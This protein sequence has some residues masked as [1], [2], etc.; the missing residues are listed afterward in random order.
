M[1][2]K[3][4]I[5]IKDLKSVSNPNSIHGIYPYR[6]KISAIDA[7][8]IIEQL[9]KVGGT[10]LDPFCGS[11]TIVYEAA[12]SGMNVVGIDNNPLAFWLTNGK[13]ATLNSD[14]DFNHE[15]EHIILKAKNNN[16]PAPKITPEVLTKAFHP[17]TF[18][19]I[20]SCL[21]FF[22]DMNNY[23]RAAFLGSIAL[24]ARACNDYKWT[25]SSVGKDIQPKRYVN[26]F[27]KFSYKARKHGTHFQTKSK[28]NIILNDARKMSSYI[29]KGSIDFVFTSP[30]YFDALDYT[31]YYGQIVY[32]LFKLNRVEIKK[33]LIQNAKKYHDDMQTVFDE[34]LKVTS[35]KAVIIF[36][37]G[38]KKIKNSIINGGVF[39]SE[40]LKHKPN[41]VLERSYTGTSSQIFDKLNKTQRKEQIVIWDKKTWK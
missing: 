35:D 26:F 2:S 33:N 5:K 23:L 10:L 21:D 6:G 1:N 11:G 39:F 15:L 36:V 40:L 16:V 28:T 34:I 37:V 32:E 3:L 12:K 41:L 9:D 18:E 4:D 7:Q 19:E 20:R 24:T 22:D 30:P 14:F 25:S 27:D 38:D 17:K 29:K 8:S 13:I 31:A